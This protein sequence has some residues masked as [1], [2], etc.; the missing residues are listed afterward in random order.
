MLCIVCGAQQNK[1]FQNGFQ[2]LLLK[3]LRSRTVQVRV[4]PKGP[5]WKRHV[6]QLRIRNVVDHESDAGEEAEDIPQTA[7]VE[8]PKDVLEPG[9]SPT[10]QAPVLNGPAPRRS[11]RIRQKTLTAPSRP[12]GRCCGDKSML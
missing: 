3:I 8:T 12:V 2:L 4:H 9:P 1:A 10:V 11:E 5:I 7:A 6:D